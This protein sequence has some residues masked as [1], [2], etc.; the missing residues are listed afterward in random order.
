MTNT[1]GKKM[2]LFGSLTSSYERTMIGWIA[3]RAQL[4]AHNSDT[5]DGDLREAN[6]NGECEAL[7]EDDS[8]LPE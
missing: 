3:V 8:Q 7:G 1:I 6:S 2:L 5:V 4:N